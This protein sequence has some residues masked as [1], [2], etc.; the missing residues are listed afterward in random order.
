MDP[1]TELSSPKGMVGRDSELGAIRTLLRSE[2]PGARSLVFEGAPG[3]GK[4]CL[5]EQGV[6]WGRE[7]G[8]RVL[9]ARASETETGLPHAALID[10]FGAV[11]SEELEAVPPPQLRALEVALYRADPGDRPPEPQVISLASLS[12]LRALAE[13]DDLLVAIDD[14]QWLDR[15]SEEAL[16]YVARRLMHERVAFLLARRPGPPSALERA[17]PEGRTERVAVGSL[18][19]AGTRQVLDRRLDLRMPPHLLHRVFETTTGNPLFVMEVGRLL[20]GRDLASVADDVPVPDQV[21]DLLGLRVADLDAAVRRV[22]VALA[23]GADLRVAQVRELAGAQALD[24]AVAAGV[25]VV[26][27]DRVRPFHPLLAAAAKRQASEDEQRDLHRSLAEVVVDEPRR[28]LHLA[29]ATVPPDEALAARTAAAADLAAARGAT[30]LAVDLAAHACRLT[31]ADVSDVDRV[32]ALCRQL[33]RAGEKRRLTELLTERLPSLP[34]GA[35]RV[36]AHLLL[37]NGHV[38]GNKEIRTHLEHALAEAGDDQLLR[39]RV[40]CFLAE[41]EA[42]IQVRDIAHADARAAEARAYS[43]QGDA[44]DQRQALYAL[45]WTR[46]LRGRPVGELVQE[47][48]A[49]SDERTYLALGPDRVAGQRLVWRGELEQARA[50]LGP[51]RV[52]ADERAELSSVALARL[53]LCELELRAGRWDA[54]EDILDEWAATDTSVLH[55][56]MF[57]RCQALLAAGRGRPEDTRRWARRAVELAESRGVGWDWLEAS[58]A[59]GLAA[60][61]DK[62]LDEA[63]RRLGAV[64]EH[65]QREGV[66]DPGAFPA[67]PDLVES[68]VESGS[69]D[70]ARAAVSVLAEAG[71]AQDHPWSRVGARRG[72]ALCEIHAGSYTD[73]AAEELAAAASEYRELGLAYDEA[74]TLL[75]LGRAARRAKKWG[76]ARDVLERAVAAFESMGAPGWAD[77]ARAELDRTGA[78]RP[79][80]DGGL[81]TTERRVADLAVQGLANKEIA[82]TL[83]VT[84]STVEFHLRNVYAKLGIRSR[85]QLA[86]G[87]QELDEP[88]A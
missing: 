76:A 33:E 64:W 9:V 57:E 60:L 5:W 70:A 80:A 6:D 59:M 54:A 19:L 1:A 2:E 75:S 15:A 47:F 36:R 69:Y 39:G 83:V 41:N 38:S 27:G 88:P 3:I 87:L 48:H 61:L 40:L 32:L 14:V 78:R 31:P 42:V 51:L 79:A 50:L 16:A 22:P 17:L 67:G 10:L 68:L 7:L 72:A 58:R 35:A 82:R 21:D 43:E 34:P 45:V 56:P 8:L 12:A 86:A 81:T 24:D 44:A 53:H 46:A 23:L 4:T 55:W 66:L 63:V 25:V 26:D 49:R 62:D 52:E 84:V 20:A 65:T 28:A 18:D 29:L 74:R 77:D 85:V 11:A 73:E 37:A 71:E 13:R 30:R